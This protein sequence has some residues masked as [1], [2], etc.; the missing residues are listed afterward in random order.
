[1]KKSIELNGKSAAAKALI[2]ELADLLPNST[3]S[4][5]ITCRINFTANTGGE[6]EQQYTNCM[7]PLRLLCIALQRMGFQREGLEQMATD[8][9]A[10][11]EA[12]WAAAEE[13]LAPAVE[14][15][16][17]RLG[18]PYIKKVAGRTTYPRVDGEATLV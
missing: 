12:E 18:K 4:G 3:E 7:K 2:Q 1:M 9:A 17:E 11:S 14:Q 13:A 15:M 10:M 6:Y 16:M 8:I 5:T